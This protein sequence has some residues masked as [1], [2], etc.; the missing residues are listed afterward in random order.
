MGRILTM[1][2]TVLVLSFSS[3]VAAPLLKEG[4]EIQ[5]RTGIVV[6]ACRV[7]SSARIRKANVAFELNP[8]LQARLVDCSAKLAERH[9]REPA[10]KIAAKAFALG[11][12]VSGAFA[13]GVM[14]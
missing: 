4:T 5:C 1:A 7:V 12:L 3:V 8:I 13:L 2:A 6:T 10:W 14:L 9:K 11:L